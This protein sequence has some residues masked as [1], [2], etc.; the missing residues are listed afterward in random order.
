VLIRER[1]RENKNIIDMGHCI[2]DPLLRRTFSSLS[3]LDEDNEKEHENDDADKESIIFSNNDAKKNGKVLLPF[4]LNNHEFTLKEESATLSA[5]QSCSS[6]PVQYLGT[7]P[8]PSLPP[9]AVS[10]KR[11]HDASIPS[12]PSLDQLSQTDTT[13]NTHR[14]KQQRQLWVDTTTSNNEIFKNNTRSSSDDG[15]YNEAMGMK[16][17]AVKSEDASTER[18]G[19]QIHRQSGTT[20]SSNHDAD[21]ESTNCSKHHSYDRKQLCD[22]DDDKEQDTTEEDD[23]WLKNHLSRLKKNKPPP[24]STAFTYDLT[25]SC[26]DDDNS[27]SD[28]DESFYGRHKKTPQ[29]RRQQ[30]KLFEFDSSGVEP[31]P[32]LDDTEKA[33]FLA[34]DIDNELDRNLQR[35][36]WHIGC[37]YNLMPYQFSGVRGVAG[38]PKDFPQLVNSSS[39]KTGSG[40]DD[41]MIF[42][43]DSGDSGANLSDHS[44]PDWKRILRKAKFMSSRGILLA[45]S[46]GLGKT[47]QGIVGAL[48]RNAISEAKGRPKLPTVLVSP[49]HAVSIQWAETLIKAGV[50]AGRIFQFM[51]K[52]SRH[53]YRGSVY[54]LMTRYHLQTET[55]YILN[56]AKPR[57]R[58]PYSPL[59]PHAP[60]PLLI[61]L[62]NQYQYGKGDRVQNLCRR[63]ES[64]SACITRLLFESSKKV[65]PAFRTIVIDEAHFLKNLKTFWGISAGMLGLHAER[66][67]PMSGT[68][69]NNGPQDMATLMTF[70]DP[71]LDAS[72]EGWWKAAT[73]EGGAAAV[74]KNVSECLSTHMIRRDKK[75]LQNRLP[76]KTVILKDIPPMPLELH[77]YEGY[78]QSF[79][80]VLDKFTRLADD[81]SP[82]AVKAKQNLCEHMMALSACMRQ[83]LI[84]AA[85]PGGGR[86][87]CINF[88]PTRRHLSSNLCDDTRCVVCKMTDKKKRKEIIKKKKES[89][90]EAADALDALADNRL[91]LDDGFIDD[92]AIDV[93]GEE[94][95]GHEIGKKKGEI[96]E[97]PP[98][99]CWLPNIRSGGLRHYAH[100]SC[101]EAMKEDFP[102]CPLC[103]SAILLSYVV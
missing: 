52:R 8:A 59:F 56:L 78:E 68:P 89:D 25:N 64:Q 99:F 33:K 49:N 92:A 11:R 80:L 69:Y 102:E 82:D 75:I 84:H 9:A 36:L 22:T 91:D 26:N 15:D 27:S 88:S 6:S 55:K 12:S 42:S 74:V 2:K 13:S 97:I 16:V 21:N 10:R 46:M 4:L 63:E 61:K 87:Y 40:D 103:E 77:V 37:R 32:E 47:V 1:Q 43:S 29:K 71:S 73:K 45:D 67:I 18:H 44:S 19:D 86:D 20:S 58:A 85:L 41:L 72:Y 24:Q 30:P 83:A 35:I 62:L 70:V 96:I 90:T 57:S 95:T 54:I 100:E 101:L 76:K 5:S 38:V 53:Q 81:N 48:L 65:G 34:E 3:S 39:K 7:K 23:K 14:R 28:E 94:G 31:L 17:E 60:N 79:L 93:N 66:C 51:P 50:S 98:E